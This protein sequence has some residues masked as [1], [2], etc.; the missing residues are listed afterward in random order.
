[1]SIDRL[2]VITMLAMGPVLIPPERLPDWLVV[3]GFASP[4]TY[5]ASALRQVLLG[6]VTA[7]LLFDLG[8][9]AGVIA[10]SF[11]LVNRRMDWRTC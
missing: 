9:L 5:A 7:H 6:P 8:I 11:W 10:R 1:M 2:L 4:A 3:I